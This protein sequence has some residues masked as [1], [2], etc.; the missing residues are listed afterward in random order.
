MEMFRQIL[1]L[2][3]LGLLEGQRMC[4]RMHNGKPV[5]PK[6]HS[7]PDSL[8][9]EISMFIGYAAIAYCDASSHTSW[10]NTN[11]KM[12][13]P[14]AKLHAEI[15]V[16][17]TNAL[18]YYNEPERHIVATFRGSDSVFR[19]LSAASVQKAAYP[20][21]PGATVTRNGLEFAT[22]IRQEI[23]ESLEAMRKKYPGYQLVLTGHSLGG[24]L[25][26][27]MAP[28]VAEDLKVPPTSIRVITFNQPRV[29]NLVFADHF[30]SQSFNFT[31]V[32]NQND[33][34]HDYPNFDHGWAHVQ[35]EV[36]VDDFNV[37]LQC[38]NYA[39]E[40]PACS[41]KK[42]SILAIATAHLHVGKTKLSPHGCGWW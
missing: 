6:L 32:T 40:D 16:D 29:G 15:K 22:S 3:L 19:F 23:V 11:I 4:K 34:V 8:M 7:V 14:K 18:T 35:R 1:V 24:V 27:L 26:T 31:R 41:F 2:V 30:N 12:L 13:H 25:A 42:S 21:V 36:H 39:V 38:N 9:K 33:P 10:W 37:F 5:F 20:G 17:D 28:M